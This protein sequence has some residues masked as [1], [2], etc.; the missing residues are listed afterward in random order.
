MV[1]TRNATI[2]P[3]DISEDTGLFAPHGGGE[4]D[5]R[6]LGRLILKDVLSNDLRIG[7]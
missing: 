3:V 6:E 7:I 1:K 2:S 5:I 4:D